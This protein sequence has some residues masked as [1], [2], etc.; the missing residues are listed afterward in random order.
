MR[1]WIE[2]QLESRQPPD[3]TRV[4]WVSERIP[5]FREKS[6]HETRS[7]KREHHWLSRS[8]TTSRGRKGYCR[9]TKVQWSPSGAIVRHEKSDWGGF[10]HHEDE[11]AW[12]IPDGTWNE[13]CF[14]H[15]QGQICWIYDSDRSQLQRALMLPLSPPVS[16]RMFENVKL[17]NTRFLKHLHQRRIYSLTLTHRETVILFLQVYNSYF[18][19]KLSSKASYRSYQAI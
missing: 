14:W 10:R 15:P 5:T 17:F 3:R 18:D 11:Y 19:C 7:K 4:R 9:L 1:E 12:C 6:Y 16:F 8:H 13:W 2:S